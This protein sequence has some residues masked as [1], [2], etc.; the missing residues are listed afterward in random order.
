MIAALLDRVADRFDAD[1]SA[2]SYSLYSGTRGPT[3]YITVFV[4][5][6]ENPVAVCRFARWDDAEVHGEWERLTRLRDLVSSSE[7][8]RTTVETPL[9]VEYVDDTPVI[10]KEFLGGQPAHYSFR[11]FDQYAETF[12][13]NATDWLVAF[14]EGT[15]D[16]RTYDSAAKREQLSASTLPG[17]DAYVEH[18]ATDDQFFLGPTHG[19]YDGTNILVGSNLDVRSVIDFEYF[20]TDGVPLVDLLKLIIETALYV[21]DSYTEATNRAFFRDCRFSRAVGRC[22][23]TYCSGVGIDERRFVDVLP[24]YPALRLGPTPRADH[25]PWNLRFYR[26]LYDT[27]SLTDAIV[28]APDCK[29]S[30]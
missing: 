23:S 9:D 6:S 10:F 20:Q 29:N 27:L 24:L 22:V 25:T 21:F 15:V 26:H 4:Y 30:R 2:L 18:F 19:D 12:L 11:H 3:G 14:A 8:L 5:E 17:S 28:W 7:R 13:S 16:A 1:R